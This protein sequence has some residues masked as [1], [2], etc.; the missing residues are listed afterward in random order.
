M[1]LAK[2][3]IAVAGTAGAAAIGWTLWTST[4]RHRLDQPRY[5]VLGHRGELELRRYEG[6][7]V[8][9]TDVDGPFDEARREARW[10]LE[11]YL[12]GR[13]VG[14]RQLP[15]TTP[16]EQ[17]RTPPELLPPLSSITQLDMALGVE[18]WRMSVMMPADADLETLPRPYDSRV[19]L[20]RVPART[21]AALRF[22]G[23]ASVE[24]LDALRDELMRLVSAHGWRTIGEPVLAV[25]D[26]AVTLPFLR[27]NE[28]QLQVELGAVA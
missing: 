10:R 9:S 15:S 3:V 14:A 12:S 27:R 21:V 24:R 28:L 4:A 7:L 8:A 23:R 18:R 17:Q 6:H 2:P 25:F 19:R 1:R 16:V 11:G 26:S 20:E 5:R 22:S 13:N